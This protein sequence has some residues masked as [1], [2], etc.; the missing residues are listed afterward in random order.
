MAVSLKDC[1]SRC[2][3]NRIFADVNKRTSDPLRY[4]GR[5]IRATQLYLLRISFL[6]MP[7]CGGPI[8]ALETSER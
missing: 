8:P 7:E 4:C 1:I 5:A 6:L 2:V 3:P